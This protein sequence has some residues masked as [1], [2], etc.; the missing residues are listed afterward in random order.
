MSKR[1]RIILIV[2]V[3]LVVTAVLSFFLVSKIFKILLIPNTQGKLLD[4]SQSTGTETRFG[5]LIGDVDETTGENSKEYQNKMDSQLKPMLHALRLYGAV[6]LSPPEEVIGEGEVVIEVVAGGEANSYKVI[7]SKNSF[8]KVGDVIPF[9]PIIGSGSLFKGVDGNK[10][11][12]SDE[13]T[14]FMIP[15]NLKPGDKVIFICGKSDCSD[16]ELVWAM[17]F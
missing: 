16:N 4:V 15:G 12:S 2:L 13:G 8:F 3:V 17:V 5:K 6:Q 10:V 1:R 9:N 11:R 7:A 14:D